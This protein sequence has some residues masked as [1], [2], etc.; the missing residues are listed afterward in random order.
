MTNRK[1]QW[2]SSVAAITPTDLYLSMSTTTYHKRLPCSA[3]RQAGQAVGG[4]T[5][6]CESSSSTTQRP[7]DEC[8]LFGL[9]DFLKGSGGV[10]VCLDVCV[11]VEREVVL[12]DS[13]TVEPAGV[14]PP[15]CGSGSTKA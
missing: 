7:G 5:F 1:M 9:S 15:G 2:C 6:T 4:P 3:R 13:P 12:I 14:E 11:S 10:T 8:S